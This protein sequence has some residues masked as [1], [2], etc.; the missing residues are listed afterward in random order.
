MAFN[1]NGDDYSALDVFFS[2][3]LGMLK[4]DRVSR[5]TFVAKLEHVVSAAATDSEAEF[6]GYI[7]LNEEQLLD[8]K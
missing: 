3:A 7:R 1:L 8:A 5:V 2:R 4:T 6:R